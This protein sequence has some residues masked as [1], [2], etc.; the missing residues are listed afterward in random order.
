MSPYKSKVKKQKGVRIQKIVNWGI[1]DDATK[2]GETKQ[3]HDS[4]MNDGKENLHGH[5]MSK[6]VKPGSKP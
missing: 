3:Q 6:R 1:L 5:P 2:R 4:R